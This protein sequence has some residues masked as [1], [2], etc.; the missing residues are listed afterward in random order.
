MHQKA[1]KT[2]MEEFEY[3]IREIFFYIGSFGIRQ[4]QINIFEPKSISDN[5][6]TEFL[7]QVHRGFRIGQSLI[8]EEILKLYEDK[9]FVKEKF[10]E[11]RKQKDKNLLKFLSTSQ[12]EIEYRINILR[13]FS[14]FIAWQL[15]KRQY[16]KARRFHSGEKERPDL[17]NTNFQSVINAVNYFHKQNSFDFALISDLT[18][19][20]DVGDIVLATKNSLIVVECKSGEIQ[21]KVNKFLDKLAGSDW[22]KAVEDLAK[23]HTNKKALKILDQAKRT[24]NQHHKGAKLSHFMNHES[25]TDTFSDAEV[26]IY[27]SKIT[28]KYYYNEIEMAFKE[29]II[30]GFSTGII[31]DIVYFTVFRDNKTGM[32]F[33]VFNSMV[34]ELNSK[35]HKTDYLHQ[36]DLPIKEPLFCKPFGEEAIFELLTGKL[37]FLLAIDIDALIALFNLKGFKARWMTRKETNKYL[38]SKP[39]YKPY[40]LQ[41]QAIQIEAG[42]HIIVL[43]SQF[44]SKILLDNVTPSSFVDQYH[45]YSE[46]PIKK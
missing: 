42:K 6:K 31:E 29:A 35:T 36:L 41:N 20:I 44:L 12:N 32:A 21:A 22:K 8:I 34:K 33:E 37:I 25:G 16:F 11:A 28:E 18:T 7:T 30:P 1:N 15:L 5:D 10:V 38:D 24:L 40:I 23:E 26:E 14:D 45:S 19:F 3:K 39:M 4:K 17:L 43:G 2:N 27:E 13:H 9:V 46:K